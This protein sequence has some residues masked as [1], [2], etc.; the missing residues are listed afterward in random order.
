MSDMFRAAI[1]RSL[2]GMFMVRWNTPPMYPRISDSGPFRSRDD[3]EMDVHLTAEA[4]RIPKYSLD[5]V[6]EDFTEGD[7]PC[8][9]AVIYE[10]PEGKEFWI[11]W[12]GPN[13][14]SLQGVFQSRAHAESGARLLGRKN[15]WLEKGMRVGHDLLAALG[16]TFVPDGEFIIVHAEKQASVPASLERPSFMW[17]TPNHQKQVIE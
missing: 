2:G 16:P 9:R 15:G 4:R 7:L 8:Y 5:I 14:G 3:A 13:V 12:E 17:S 6:H 11:S 1:S 10:S